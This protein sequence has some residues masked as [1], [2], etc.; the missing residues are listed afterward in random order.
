MTRRAGDPQ[1]LNKYAY[2]YNSPLRFNDP[3][4][5]CGVCIAVAVV[6]VGYGLYE[7]YKW[8]KSMVVAKEGATQNS[9]EI[10]THPNE[11]LDADVGGEMQKL[12]DQ[13]QAK[14]MLGGIKAGADI[15][16]GV[17]VLEGAAEGAVTRSASGAA[18]SRPTDAM[19][20]QV[21][22]ALRDAHTDAVGKT[23]GIVSQTLSSQ[24]QAQ[25]Q[26]HE[27]QQKLGDPSNKPLK[28]SCSPHAPCSF[29]G[30][31]GTGGQAKP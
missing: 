8:V 10:V 17:S 24:Q 1:S 6:V 14:D 21:A 25:Q 2:T 5:H 27:Q 26:Q 7:G 22:G 29:G 12:S 18:G 9:V 11:H 28:S 13:Q 3:N 15:L 23:A 30:D 20:S 31:N 16:T 19:A 4:G